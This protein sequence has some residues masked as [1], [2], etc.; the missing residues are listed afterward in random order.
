MM[1]RNFRFF[2][3]WL[4]LIK[5]VLLLSGILLLNWLCFSQKRA[6]EGKN[7]VINIQCL[8]R[9]LVEDRIDVCRILTIVAPLILPIDDRLMLIAES[10]IRWLKMLVLNWLLHRVVQRVN[11]AGLSKISLVGKV[12]VLILWLSE[13]LVLQVWCCDWVSKL[14]AWL[15]VHRLLDVLAMSLIW[16][17]IAELLG[18]ARRVG[19]IRRVVVVGHKLHV[20]Y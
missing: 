9:S 8:D 15:G 14:C 11:W 19:L 20:N 13:V 16:E 1:R 3:L 4:L 10:C 7:W 2:S 5:R 17:T 12:L 18:L 6:S